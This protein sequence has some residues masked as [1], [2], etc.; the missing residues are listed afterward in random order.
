MIKSQDSSANLSYDIV[1][2]LLSSDTL[3]ELVTGQ[4]TIV[5][6]ANANPMIVTSVTD[7]TLQAVK[8]SIKLLNYSAISFEQ[9]T[10]ITV[11]NPTGWTLIYSVSPVVHVTSGLSDYRV[12]LTAQDGVTKS[13]IPLVIDGLKGNAI[14]S[15]KT[16]QTTFDLIGNNIYI[17]DTTDKTALLAAID[18]VD[19]QSVSVHKNTE[20]TM[21]AN[22]TLYDFYYVEVKAQDPI[23]PAQIYTIT[24]LSSNTNLVTSSFKPNDDVTVTMTVDNVN[25]TITFAVTGKASAVTAYQLTRTDITNNFLTVSGQA[26]AFKTSES[27]IK[28]VENVFTDDKL[29][30][31]AADRLLISVPESTATYK[32]IVVK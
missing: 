3:H 14:L 22:G 30:V 11:A 1:P 10:G 2:N 16:G 28:N 20:E 23:V 12:V 25:K 27:L 17:S 7:V 21:I 19:N 6:P 32:I 4:T 18:V 9:Y 29:V 15:P 24:V 8:N 13:Y 26:Y 5:S 31:T